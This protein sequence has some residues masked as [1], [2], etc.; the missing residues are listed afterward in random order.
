[1]PLTGDLV[2]NFTA[3]RNEIMLGRV[4]IAVTR[5]SAPMTE[6][7]SSTTS[8]QWKGKNPEERTDFERIYVDENF[9][10][11]SGI[12]ILEGRDMDLQKF[13][14]DSTAALVNQTALKVMG[15]EDPI[16]EIINDNGCDWHIIGIVKDFIFTS[17]YQKVEPIVLFGAKPKRAFNIIYVKLNSENR[18][19]D[20]LSKLSALSKKHNP[21]YPFEYHFA[22]VEYQRKFDN[23][24]ATLSITTVFSSVAIFIACLGLLGLTTYMTEARVKEIGIRKVMGGS[25]MS[26]TR[27]LG[28]TSLKPIVISI[29]LF[30]PVSWFAMRWWLESFAFR[31]QLNGWIFLASA[32]VLLVIASLT[33][34]MNTLRAGAN[35]V[36]SLRNE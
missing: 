2:K 15:L 23:M 28:Y 34:A 17:P 22:D 16:G 12:T 29:L 24:Q 18:N 1:M 30:T 36:E 10:A 27:L 14:T 11:T 6:Q 13:P 35:P 3:F 8:M 4:A 25:M 5:T 26:I 21:D 33:V 31:I 7:W 32:F 9:A 20:N 19:E